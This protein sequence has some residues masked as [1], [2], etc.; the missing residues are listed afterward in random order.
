MHVMTEGGPLGSTTT[1]TY[2]LYREA[3]EHFAMGRA[4]AVACVLFALLL[5]LTLIQFKIVGSRVHYE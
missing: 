4:S 2:L 1:I 3:F 5:A